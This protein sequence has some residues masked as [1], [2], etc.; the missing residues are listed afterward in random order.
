MRLGW[1]KQ[2]GFLVDFDLKFERKRFLRFVSNRFC[3]RSYEQHIYGRKTI[4]CKNNNQLGC[5]A[6]IAYCFVTSVR[7]LFDC[8][9]FLKKIRFTFSAEND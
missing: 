7:R 9:K 4:K 3:L 5:F 2:T 8:R 1:I 6:N